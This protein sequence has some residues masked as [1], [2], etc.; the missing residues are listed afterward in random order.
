MKTV[1]S[2]VF[3]LFLV[4]ACSVKEDREVCPC[5]LTLD[6]KGVDTTLVRRAN[7][8][9]TSSE[10]IVFFDSVAVADFDKEYVRNVPHRAMKINVWGGTGTDE[11]LQIPYGCECPHLY[12]H[13]FEPDLSGEECHEKILLKKN[14]CCLTVLLDGRDDMPYCLTFRGNVDGYGHDGRPSGGEFACV[15]YP[16][17]DGGSQVVVPR[18]KDSSLL[19]EVDDMKAPFTK[20]FAIGEYLD[21]AGYDWTATELDD[22]D[23]VIDY[24]LTGIKITFK[25]WDKEYSYDIIL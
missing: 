9:A 22:A 12:M 1:L 20:T 3:L 4:V 7:I 10:G 25:G 16:A 23:V 13:T 2:G 5:R 17:E 14:H 24:Y 21:A 11:D 6:F 15:A 8:L 18:Q 19:L